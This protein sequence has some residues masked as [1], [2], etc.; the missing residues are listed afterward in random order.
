MKK[1][2][3]ETSEFTAR[4]LAFLS[5]ENYRRL[6][7]LLLANPDAGKVMLGCGGM[8]K[9]PF[10][11]ER[12]NKGKRGGLRIIYLHVPD[13]NRIYLVHIYDKGQLDDLNAKQ[14]KVLRT[15][16]ETFKSE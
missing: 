12:R 6:Q 9:L 13:T 4:A 2:F 3:I 10:A 15:L 7:S 16:A 1:L 11:D 14:K 5:E 8:R